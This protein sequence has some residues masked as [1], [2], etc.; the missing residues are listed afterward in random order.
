LESMVDTRNRLEGGAGSFPESVYYS[1]TVGG[2]ERLCLI[3][4]IQFF[5]KPY[6]NF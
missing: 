6:I 4:Q 5:L 1:D 3:F 2:R